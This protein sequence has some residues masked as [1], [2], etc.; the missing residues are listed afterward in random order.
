MPFRAFH[1]QPVRS[2]KKIASMAERSGVRWRWQPSGCGGRGGKSGSICAQ[3]QSGTRQPSSAQRDR[4]GK[5]DERCVIHPTWG[6]IPIGIGPKDD[7]VLEPAPRPIIEYFFSFVSLWS[8][9]GSRTFR[10]LAE[11]HGV[12]VA[13]KPIDLLAIFAAGSGKPVK[14]RPAQRQAYRLI[15]MQRWRRIRDIPL[16]LHPRFYPADP[17]LAHRVLLGGLAEGSNVAAFAHAGLSAVWADELDIA[18]ADTIVRLAD[19]AG[20]DGRRL[21]AGADAPALREREAALTREAIGRPMFGAPF[22]FYRDEPFW[23]QDRLDMLDAAL[24]DERAPIPLSAVA[25]AS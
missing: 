13:Y 3:S 18:D 21:L 1:W 23:G 9:V 22:Y 14:E 11:R 25:A 12:N 10:A 16:V 2:T 20:L 15:E 24:S 4:S 5:G 19:G 6:A 7:V 17:S 8:Y